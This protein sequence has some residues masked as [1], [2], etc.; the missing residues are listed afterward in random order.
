MH[1]NF[2]HSIDELYDRQDEFEGDVSEDIMELQ[3]F[4][5]KLGTLISIYSFRLLS[6]E[7]NLRLFL[8]A[9]KTLFYIVLIC[10]FITCIG[11]GKQI[12][13]CNIGKYFV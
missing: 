10:D 7:P 13:Y 11:G 9:Y 5:K 2:S 12:F 4:V 8:T 1:L 6:E 3:E